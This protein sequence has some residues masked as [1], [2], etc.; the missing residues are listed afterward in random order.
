L[1]TYHPDTLYWREQECKDP[2]LCFEARRCPR[3]KSFRKQWSTEWHIFRF[4]WTYVSAAGGKAG[5]L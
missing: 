5:K 4:C 1:G 3:A 2:W